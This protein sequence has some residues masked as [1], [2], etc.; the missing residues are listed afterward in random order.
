LACEAIALRLPVGEGAVLDML[1]FL[2]VSSPGSLTQKSA[3]G[4]LLNIFQTKTRS[5]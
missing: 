5:K 2:A 4:N 3:A 1:A